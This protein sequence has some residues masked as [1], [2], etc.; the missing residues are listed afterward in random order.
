MSSNPALQFDH[1]AATNSG[2]ER[3][4]THR[5]KRLSAGEPLVLGETV[6]KWYRLSAE[7]SEILSDIAALGRSRL[8]SGPIEARGMGFAVLHRCGRDFYFLLVST[9]R[10]TNEVWESVYFKDGDG[11]SSF[12]PFARDAEHKPTFCV[13]ELVAVMHEQRAWERFLRSPRDAAAAREWLADT[14]EGLA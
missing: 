8:E 3:G 11:M 1:I 7:D 9:W 10:N 12:E 5:P 13:W 14:Y 4:Y 2:V 6:L